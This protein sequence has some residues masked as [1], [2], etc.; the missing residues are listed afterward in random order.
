MNSVCLKSMIFSFCIF[1]KTSA[2]S[3]YNITHSWFK[4]EWFT[5][6]PYLQEK[7]CLFVYSFIKKQWL[8]PPLKRYFPQIPPSGLFD[9]LLPGYGSG[10]SLKSK[11]LYYTTGITCQSYIKGCNT[12]FGKTFVYAT[13]SQ[14]GQSGK[15]QNAYEM[16]K[17]KSEFILSLRSRPDSS[18]VFNRHL[19]QA[20]FNSAST[21][22]LLLQSVLNWQAPDSSCQS[23]AAATRDGNTHGENIALHT[24]RGR[25][26]I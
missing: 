23:L 22:S 26:V 24:W 19:K 13:C 14:T 6:A 18:Q 1:S 4:G 10:V 11:P 15:L 5:S 25:R 8:A 2:G 9:I 20:A 16:H 21:V 3:V 17:C 12:L 7:K